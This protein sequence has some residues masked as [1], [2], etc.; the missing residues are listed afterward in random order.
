MADGEDAM[1]ILLSHYYTAAL[2]HVELLRRLME[3]RQ[4]VRYAKASTP[5]VLPL[6]AS[7][8]ST[9][10]PPPSSPIVLP[11]RL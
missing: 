11:R 9:M 2:Q 5:V 1:Q 7:T 4:E 10:P 6:K 8:A 3:A